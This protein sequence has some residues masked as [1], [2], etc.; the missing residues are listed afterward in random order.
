MKH[1]SNPRRGRGRNNGKR[2]QNPRSRNFE[3][4]GS[5]QKVRG[6]AQQVLDK[7]LALARDA[8]SAG[9]RIAAEGFFQHA[10]HYYRI[11]HSEDAAQVGK[12]N[13]DRNRQ[14]QGPR[15]SDSS[16]EAQ[17]TSSDNTAKMSK[18]PSKDRGDVKEATT[19][20]PSAA[21]DGSP[22]EPEA[23]AA[24]DSPEA[25]DTRSEEKPR[26]RGRPR[27]TEVAE[28]APKDGEP[29]ETAA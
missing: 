26:R 29:S 9:D 24:P 18:K 15:H 10:E 27:K 19:S 13:N 5:D 8:T 23:Q 12:P 17:E 3:S 25:S 16:E 11:L 20:T 14:P 22:V 4:G 2:N 28:E 1:A 6:T 7:Y 21:T